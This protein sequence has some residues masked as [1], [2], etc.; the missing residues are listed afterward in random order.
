MLAEVG[1]GGFVSPIALALVEHLLDDEFDVS[2]LEFI[3]SAPRHFPPSFGLSPMPEAR[4]DRAAAPGHTIALPIRAAI[5]GYSFGDPFTFT[6]IALQLARDREGPF[7]G[8]RAISRGA[9][10]GI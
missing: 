10:P 2:S 7:G 9:S 1:N 8:A 4:R 6:S 5:F 3:S